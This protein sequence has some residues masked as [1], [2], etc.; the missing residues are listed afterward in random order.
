MY[1]IRSYYDKPQLLVGDTVIPQNGVLVANAVEVD[2]LVSGKVPMP[3]DENMKG[4]VGKTLVDPLVIAERMGL[5]L[6]T[7]KKLP[8]VD[9][10]SVSIDN[11]SRI[12]IHPLRHELTM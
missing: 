4:M 2:N 5:A 3:E 10:P 7:Y 6:P 8:D 12:R 1:A 11:V 9:E